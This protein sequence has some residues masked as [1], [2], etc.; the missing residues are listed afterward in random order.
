MSERDLHTELLLLEHE[1]DRIKAACGKIPTG[2]DIDQHVAHMRTALMRANAL[3]RQ[4]LGA[5]KAALVILTENAEILE[6]SFLPEPS[7]AEAEELTEAH[8]IMQQVTEQIAAAE[9]YLE[10][11]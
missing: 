7:D 11:K 1:R 4:T 6:R 5:A 8:A 9:K 3:L 2:L 10:G